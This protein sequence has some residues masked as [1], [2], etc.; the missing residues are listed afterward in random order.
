MQASKIIKFLDDDKF[1]L[2]STD[3]VGRKLNFI[4]QDGVTG[5][6][7]FPEAMSAEMAQQIEC[8]SAQLVIGRDVEKLQNRV[9]GSHL[10]TRSVN[11]D[12]DEIEFNLTGSEDERVYI[13]RIDAKKRQESFRKFLYTICRDNTSHEKK[14]EIKSSLRM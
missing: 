14:N 9:K 2:L 12:T 11:H 7:V 13:E 1:K 8:N 10:F 5:E 4:W 6:D 3:E